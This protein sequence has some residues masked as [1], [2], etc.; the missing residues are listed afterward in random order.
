[1]EFSQEYFGH[2]INLAKNGSPE[3][4]CEYMIRMK[5]ST[6]N[7]KGIGRICFD[8]S[9]QGVCAPMET[10]I[11]MLNSH[12]F[13]SNHPTIKVSIPGTNEYIDIDKEI[14]DLI[15]KMWVNFILTKASCQGDSEGK[16]YI[17]FPEKR[18]L[19]KLLT[20]YPKILSLNVTFDKIGNGNLIEISKEEV[21]ADDTDPD[22][23]YSI[24]FENKIIGQIREA[25]N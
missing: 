20:L 9:S 23:F 3:L 16:G 21:F 7:D 19:I 11:E 6:I 15:K 2:C 1:M 22:V 10:L 18:Y 13:D 14:A 5:P 8:L 12:V 4:F 25:M 17:S 24:R